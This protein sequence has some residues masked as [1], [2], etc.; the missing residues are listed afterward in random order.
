MVHAAEGFIGSS[1]PVIITDG[2]LAT[3]LADQGHDLSDDLWSARLL[4]DAPAAIRDAHLA[5]FRA[6]ATPAGIAEIAS[7]LAS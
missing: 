2:G 1:G 3:E 6:G 7:L 5:Y 4:V